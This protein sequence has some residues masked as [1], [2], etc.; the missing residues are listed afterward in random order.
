MT[1]SVGM[2]CA[3]GFW[4]DATQPKESLWL[5]RRICELDNAKASIMFSV[6]MCTKTF[7]GK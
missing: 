5:K 3:S 4:V 2:T 7:A 6:Y 1:L